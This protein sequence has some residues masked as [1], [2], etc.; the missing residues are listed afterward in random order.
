MTLESFDQISGYLRLLKAVSA[1]YESRITAAAAAQGLT[2]P[3]ADVLLFLA[4]NPQFRTARE[5][6]SRRG[7]SKAYVSKAVEQLAGRGFLTVQVSAA[8]RRV[9]QLRLT[10]AAQGPAKALRRAQLECFRQLTEGVTPEEST[11]LGRLCQRVFENLE[12]RE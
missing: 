5:V 6:V 8:D 1:R 7:L 4:N 10:A 12:H 9:Q 11:A 3:E 2:K